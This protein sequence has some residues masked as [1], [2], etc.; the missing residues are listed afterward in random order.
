MK[1]CHLIS[2][3]YEK[4]VIISIGLLDS[5]CASLVTT[6]VCVNLCSTDDANLMLFSVCQCAHPQTAHAHV[7]IPVRVC[8]CACMRMCVCVCMCVCIHDY[9][10]NW[11]VCG[12]R[13][14][15]S[16]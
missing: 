9:C 6:D 2:V 11:A 10:V 1:S 5:Y 15:T 14:L 3:K 7:H 13:P 4:Q 8:V 16:T 12:R